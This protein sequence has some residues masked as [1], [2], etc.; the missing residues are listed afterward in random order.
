VNEFPL[1]GVRVAMLLTNPYRPDVRV[2]KEAFTLAGAGAEVVV[3]AWDRRGKLPELEEPCRGVTIRRLYISSRDGLGVRQLPRFVRYWRAVAR[4]VSAERWD[5]L[6]AHDLD[7]LVAAVITRRRG[8][9]LVYDAHEL[10]ALMV[11]HRLGPF[12]ERVSWVL[13]RCLVRRAD[14]V[15]TDGR[16][17]ARALQRVLRIPL[18]VAVENT[19]PAAVGSAPAESR[20]SLRH[21]H[22]IPGD[23]WVVGVFA[24]L[25]K[26]KVLAPLWEALDGWPD[27]WV[28]VAG[29]GPEA[30]TVAALATR[31]PRVRYLGYVK[32]LAPWYK[33]VDMIYYALSSMTR[34]SRLGFP[35]NV[36]AA[37]VAGVPLLVA[38]VGEC[39]R[40]VRRY[41]LGFVMP[42]PSTRY[43]LQG[44]AALRRPDTYASYVAAASAARPRFTWEQA[45]RKLVEA[46][47]RLLKRT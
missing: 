39:G 13:E 25:T 28:V 34:N 3:F 45:G 33:A 22:S 11:G 30:A 31:H 43:V 27:S 12:A 19:A 5:V 41:R 8:A 26:A 46:Y 15:I 9:R 4:A 14:L 20:V 24:S 37:A 16:A 29:E 2:Q 17:R 44:M 32:D 42:E 38:D 35:N 23:A 7:G 1:R 36:A 18:P 6:H 10:F 40:L 21:A 47:Q